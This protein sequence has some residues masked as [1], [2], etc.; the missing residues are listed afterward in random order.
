MDL[1]GCVDFSRVLEWLQLS[2]CTHFPLSS[3]CPSG[4]KHP[5]TQRSGQP[6]ANSLQDGGQALPH[7]LN[8]LPGGQLGG[9]RIGGGREGGGGGGI[10]GKRKRGS[11]MD[12]WLS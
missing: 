10:A 8:I 1:R 7:S 11:K 12:S 2:R 3:Y 5:A 9:G 4:Q 6:V